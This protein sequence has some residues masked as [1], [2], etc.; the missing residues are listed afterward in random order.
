MHQNRNKGGVMAEHTK[1]HK[2]TVK[3]QKSLQQR[4][5]KYRHEHSL[6][7]AAFVLGIT[8][9]VVINT[10]FMMKLV[11]QNMVK[12]AEGAQ[13]VVYPSRT[14]SQGIAENGAFQ[15][16]IKRVTT[17]DNKDP[18]FSL[19]S[20]KTMLIMDFTIKNTTK[21]MQQFIPV[22]QLYVRSE[23]GTYSALHMSSHVTDPVLAQDLQPGES[24]S[25]QVSFLV[26]KKASM[27]LLYIDTGW[28]KATP[29]VIDVLH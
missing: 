22:I 29:L 27:P 26:S 21:S 11:S 2:H 3:K 9:L 23:D 19:D 4:F 24:A 20:D 17:N 1:K 5:E 16:S 28:D 15:T 8:A 7:F 14:T 12:M 6:L 10:L 25:G 13:V 18:M